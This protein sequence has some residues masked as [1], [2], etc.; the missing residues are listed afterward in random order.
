MN[1]EQSEI[2]S[3]RVLDH[4][5][6]DSLMEKRRIWREIAQ[7]RWVNGRQNATTILARQFHKNIT[8]ECIDNL[9]E[10]AQLLLT[11]PED[12]KLVVSIDQAR[13][14]TNKLSLFD[15]I[16]QLYFCRRKTYGRV[17]IDRPYDTVRL[18]RSTHEFR[19][20]FRHVKMTSAEKDT[21]VAFLRAQQDQVRLSPGLQAWL[22]EPF[23]RSQ[24]YFFVDHTGMGWLTL[25]SL[26]RPGLIRK[27]LHIIPAK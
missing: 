18:K 3:L 9:H 13:V 12:F 10:L 27:T 8:E 22:P 26:V 14:Y 24:D 2:N 21:L 7:Q 23:N 6:I 5:A 1:F 11:A 25:L 15:R 19:T 16:D 20:Y 4:A 17:Q